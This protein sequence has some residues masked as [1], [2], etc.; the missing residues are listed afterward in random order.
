MIIGIN[1]NPPLKN[2][3]IPVTK[4]A[5]PKIR[6]ETPFKCVAFPHPKWSNDTTGGE[7]RLF[8]GNLASDPNHLLRSKPLPALN[9]IS[10]QDKG[11]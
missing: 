11:R 6:L 9:I 5:P 10:V 3:D 2:I 1:V 7:K 8:R 4:S